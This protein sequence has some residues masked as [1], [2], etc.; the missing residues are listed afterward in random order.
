MKT[1]DI[2]TLTPDQLIKRVQEL[3]SRLQECPE[4]K[5]GSL[6]QKQKAEVYDIISRVMGLDEDPEYMIQRS[7]DTS[8]VIETFVWAQLERKESYPGEVLTDEQFEYMFKH[9]TSL[10]KMYSILE[11]EYTR[12]NNQE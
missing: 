8:I 9:L 6:S 12:I 2:T 10:R 1:T 11:T 3:E 4:E 7:M 5:T